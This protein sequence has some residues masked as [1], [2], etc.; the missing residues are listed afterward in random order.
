MKLDG[1]TF[2]EAMKQLEIR[3]E[4]LEKSDSTD[5]HKT[6]EEAIELK[7][8]CS[9]LLKRE[10]EEIIKVAK[11]NNIAL[12]DIGLEEESTEDSEKDENGVR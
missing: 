9:E 12:S 6:Y 2:D 7:E 1:L 8:Y 4:Q 5:N 3:I 10:K 11:E